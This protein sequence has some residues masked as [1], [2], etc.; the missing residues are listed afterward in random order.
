M[1]A[2]KHGGGRAENKI[3]GPFDITILEILPTGIA[4]NGVL[5]S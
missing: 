2:L 4:V 5:P 3:G 1:A